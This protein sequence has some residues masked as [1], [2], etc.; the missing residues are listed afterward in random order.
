M[1]IEEAEKLA[2]QTLKNV[3]E[4]KINKYNVEV[5]TLKASDGKFTIHTPLHVNEII[6]TLS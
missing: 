4:E 5:A 6:A 2:L 3:M 1:W